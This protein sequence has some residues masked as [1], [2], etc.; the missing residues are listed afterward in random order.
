[1]NRAAGAPSGTPR[2]S[3]YLYTDIGVYRPE[4]GEFDVPAALERADPDR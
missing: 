3:Q 2:V 1:V 4:G